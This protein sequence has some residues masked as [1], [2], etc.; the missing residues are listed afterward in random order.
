MFEWK[1]VDDN[2]PFIDGWCVVILGPVNM[3]YKNYKEHI[4]WIKSFGFEKAWCNNG[5]FWIADYHG[6]KSIDVTKR[7]L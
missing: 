7:G 6:H 3:E 1:K 2:Y 5:N 4:N